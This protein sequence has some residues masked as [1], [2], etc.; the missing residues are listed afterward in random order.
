MDE[1]SEKLMIIRSI[2]ILFLS[3]ILVC[4]NN[5]VARESIITYISWYPSFGTVVGCDK[6]RDGGADYA[7]RA[8]QGANRPHVGERSLASEYTSPITYAL[9]ANGGENI[10]TELS[11]IKSAGFDVVAYDMLPS[12]APKR[13]VFTHSAYCGLDL[14]NRVGQI[15]DRLDLKVA[16]FSDIK[17]ISA[18]FPNGYTFNLPEWQSAYATILK[19]YGDEPWYWRPRGRPAI[20]QFGATVGAIKGFQGVNAIREWGKIANGFSVSGIPLDIFLDVR[21]NDYLA[22]KIA[23]GDGGVMPFLF[24]PGA[25][26]R[27]SNKF[28]K[29]LAVRTPYPVWSVSP[30]YYNRKL[31]AYLP[32]DF[33]RIH[34]AYSSALV[35]NAQAMLVATWNDF[36]EETDI[37]HSTHKSNGLLKV[38]EFYNAWFKS[39]VLPSLPKP[40]IIFAIP[41][42]S[43]DHTQSAPPTWGG[44]IDDAKNH[45]YGQVVYYWAYIKGDGW[46]TINGRKV[47]L[48]A[49]LNI[50]KENIG[51]VTAV[52]IYSPFGGRATT[53]IKHIEN[54]GAN[55]TDPGMTFVYKILEG[56]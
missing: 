51:L 3:I 28:L 4:S 23:D 46:F 7:K 13:P 33:M 15:A 38:F 25:P 36:E 31:R 26:S 50:G 47:N 1:L 35:N 27:F 30:G 37:V 10:K 48:R 11:Q 20:F 17:N 5:A 14:F 43:F 44:G 24:A 52:N 49:G 32:P 55:N 2:L 29:D 9:S 53:E 12:P 45:P 6:W 41:S 34:N 22:L 21:P 19:Y 40:I 42:Y 56:K 39:G 16:V 54:E 8:I 18:D